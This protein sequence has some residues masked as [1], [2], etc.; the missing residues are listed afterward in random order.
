VTSS[1]RATAISFALV[2]VVLVA[3]T[4]G[5]QMARDRAYGDLRVEERVLYVPSGQLLEKMALSYDSLLAD[6][7]WIRALQHYGG[8]RRSNR[9]QRFELLYPLLDITTTLD[10]RFAIAYRF[11]ATFLSEPYPGGA[12]RPDLAIQLLEKGVR[13]QPQ[14]WQYHEDIGFIHYQLGEYQAAAREFQLGGDL[15]GSPWWL[16]SLAAV[17]L[18]RGGSRE[19]SRFLWQRIL[20]EATDAWLRDNATMRLMQL[21]AL[22]Q[23][24]ALNARIREYSRR[25]GHLPD[26][27]EAMIA[28]GLLSALP[29]D[30]TG[31]PFVLNRSTGEATLMP[32][33]RLAPLPDIRSEGA[34]IS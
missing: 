23:I 20:A 22:D 4:V 32:A 9:A 1:N 12:G 3:G 11:G 29:V 16:R 2:L 34:P 8:D 31:V 28:A 13:A 24:D 19:A 7:Y 17:T 18:T 14:K 30:P 5:L 25:V 27:W 6:V 26:S 15:P 33:S 21:D 10:P